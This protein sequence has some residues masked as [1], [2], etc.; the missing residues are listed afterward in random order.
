MDQT[1]KLA[2]DPDS[3][4]SQLLNRLSCGQATDKVFRK[5]YR[6]SKEFVRARQDPNDIVL[7]STAVV[8]QQRFPEVLDILLTFLD[9][10]DMV[11]FY[12][13]TSF[14]SNLQEIETDPAVQKENALIVVKHMYIE[15][16]DLF[17][18]LEVALVR[19][20]VLLQ[21]LGEVDPKR[22]LANSSGSVCSFRT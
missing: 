16:P 3:R 6:Y 2:T 7:M 14:H 22:R 13:L 12:S 18:G 9:K 20:S 21:S 5:L 15:H 17:Q 10:S 11:R 1:P 19:K 4:L 8:W